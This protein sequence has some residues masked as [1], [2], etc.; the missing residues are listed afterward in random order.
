M[1]TSK[2]VLLPKEQ[3]ETF[4]RSRRQMKRKPVLRIQKP[5]A[6]TQIEA[7]RKALKEV[8]RIRRQLRLRPGWPKRLPFKLTKLLPLELDGSQNEGSVAPVMVTVMVRAGVS[9]D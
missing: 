7:K 3:Y 4:K 9:H 8:S 1:K 5:L 2:L 6:K